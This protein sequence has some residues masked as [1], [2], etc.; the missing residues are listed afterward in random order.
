LAFADDVSRA[1]SLDDICTLAVTTAASLFGTERVS[2]WLEDRCAASF[3]EP[4]VEGVEALLVEGDGV[5]GRLVLEL[6]EGG[7]EQQRLL[8]S[9]ASQASVAIQKARLY[10]RQLETAEIANT[11]LEASRELATAESADETLA[12]C[13]D[14]TRRALGTTRAALWVQAEG[15]T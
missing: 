9:F 7:E 8:A 14:V 6:G 4:I 13:V 1:Q 11:L 3:G 12:R 5:L 15:A 2:L 10:W